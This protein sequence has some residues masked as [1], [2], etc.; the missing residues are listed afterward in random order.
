MNRFKKSINIAALLLAT[1]FMAGC[2][3]GV[4]SDTHAAAEARKH[5]DAIKGNAATSSACAL[6]TREEAHKALG[7]KVSKGKPSGP[8]GS[9]CQ[10]ESTRDENRFIQVQ[11]VPARYWEDRHAVKGYRRLEGI[12]QKAYVVPELGDWLVAVQTQ[13]DAVFVSLPQKGTSEADAIELAKIV[14]ERLK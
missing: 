10:W 9:A 12:G 6:L 2:D 11:L 4:A 14:V 8:M 13:K 3:S 1:S 7:T 5:A